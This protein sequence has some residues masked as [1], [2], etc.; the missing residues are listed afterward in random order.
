MVGGEITGVAFFPGGKGT[1]NNENIISD[2][3]IMILGQDFDCKDNFEVSK[4]NGKEDIRKNP[5]WRNLLILLGEAGISNNDCFFTNAILGVRK[6]NKGT[7]KSPAFKSPEF[8]AG[9]QQ[10]FLHQIEVQK[11]EAIFVLGKFTAKFLA[12]MSE[13]LNC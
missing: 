2:K 7:G 3:K 8:I 10:F 4:N 13:R 12:N 5:T 1:F 11:P 6:G 9:C